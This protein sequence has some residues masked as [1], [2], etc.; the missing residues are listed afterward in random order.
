MEFVKRNLF[1]L[2]IGLAVVALVVL[3]LLFVMPLRR[4]LSKST[5][6]LEQG[7]TRLLALL[8]GDIANETKI[9]KAKQ[10]AGVFR[11]QYETVESFFAGKKQKAVKYWADVFIDGK[12]EPALFVVEYRKRTKVLEEKL[13]KNMELGSTAFQWKSFGDRLPEPKDCE[14]PMEHF[15]MM[16]QIAELIERAAA[17]TT[18]DSVRQGTGTDRMFLTVRDLEF[19]TRSLT[20]SGMVSFPRLLFLVAELERSDLNVFVDTLSVK[21]VETQLVGTEEPPVSV[22]VKCSMLHGKKKE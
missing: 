15:R 11:T 16:E 13:K 3:Y 5:N 1:W 9:D 17:V 18:L 4:E 22:S 10:T 19:A 2:G 8:R 12:L 6:E 20:I 21:Q 14:A 7:Q